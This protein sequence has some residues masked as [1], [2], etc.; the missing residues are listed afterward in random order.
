MNLMWYISGKS[1]PKLNFLLDECCIGCGLCEKI[2]TTKR[3]KMNENKPEWI[4]ENCNFCYACFNYC[5]VQAIGVKH[6]TKKLGRYHHPEI[7]S[8]DIACQNK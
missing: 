4:N 6:Y 3:I 7:N 8:E 5:P 1:K 2:C